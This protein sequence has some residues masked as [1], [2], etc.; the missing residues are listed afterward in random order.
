MLSVDLATW[1]YSWL[2]LSFSIVCIYFNPVHKIEGKVRQWDK[3]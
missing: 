1:V 2:A 3:Q